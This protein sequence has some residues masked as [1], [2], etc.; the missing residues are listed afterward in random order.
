MNYK[1]ILSVLFISHI[2]TIYLL[3][4]TFSLSNN[5]EII[6]EPTLGES[7]SLMTDFFLQI[8]ILKGKICSAI[9]I[10]IVGSIP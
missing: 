10:S 1:F 6:T 5:Y 9:F 7:D 2:M 8:Y 4:V 3:L